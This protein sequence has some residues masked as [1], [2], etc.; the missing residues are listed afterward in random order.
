MYYFSVA[1][2]TNNHK[3]S[4]LNQHKFVILK[5]CV[6]L[7]LNKNVDRVAFLSAGSRGGSMSSCLGSRP[8][9]SFIKTWDVAA[10]LT[11]FFYSDLPLTL[12]W[13]SSSV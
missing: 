5:V 1:P 13:E 10:L 2:I 12:N 6:S 7:G 4:D 11:T 8:P 9:S 3:R